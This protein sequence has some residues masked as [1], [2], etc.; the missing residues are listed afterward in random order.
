MVSSWGVAVSSQAYTH[1][2]HAQ[3]CQK[4][5]QAHQVLQ[6]WVQ[7]KTSGS[8]CCARIV[9]AW[10]TNDGADFW[11]VAAVQPMAFTGSFPVKAVRQCLGLDG[12]CACAGELDSIARELQAMG[13]SLDDLQKSNPFNAW[14]TEVTL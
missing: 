13:Y 8:A 11:K 7:V 9:D 6:Q 12:L 3:A 1:A 14:M 5:A 10:T 2:M 4:A